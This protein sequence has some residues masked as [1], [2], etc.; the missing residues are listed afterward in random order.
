[1]AAGG[2]C[3]G[4]AGRAGEVM[5]LA[6]GAALVGGGEV[7]GEVAC[8]FGALLEGVDLEAVGAE[9]VG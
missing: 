4:G 9:V 6:P 5:E 3:G 8:R 7:L 1:M 2:A